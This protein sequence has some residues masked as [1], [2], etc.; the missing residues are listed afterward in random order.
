MYGHFVDL[1]QAYVMGMMEALQ[2]YDISRGVPFLVFKELPAMNAVHTYTTPMA[3]N[4]WTSPPVSPFA[5][6]ATTIPA[7]MKL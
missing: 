7:T 2:R 5:H 3:K 1:K 4:I 6:L